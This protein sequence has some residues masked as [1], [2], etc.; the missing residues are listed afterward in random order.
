MKKTIAFAIMV[1]GVGTA[2]IAHAGTSTYTTTGGAMTRVG[3]ETP[4]G[5]MFGGSLQ[6][7]TSVQTMA[8]GSKSDESWTCIGVS[9]P[10]HDKIFDQH[11]ACD[12]TSAAGDYSIIFGCDNISKDGKQGCVGGL[13]GKTGAYKG[14]GG[15]TTWAG[16]DGTGVGTAQWND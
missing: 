9:Q 7:G 1:I 12:V 2:S 8:D 5:G 15:A 14:K 13:Y 4:D 11:V 16:K 6:V 3:T 10:P